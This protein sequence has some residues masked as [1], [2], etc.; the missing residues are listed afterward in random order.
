MK[1]IKIIIISVL[2]FVIVFVLVNFLLAGFLRYSCSCFTTL[3]EASCNCGT[4]LWSLVIPLVLAL[5]AAIYYFYRSLSSIKSNQKV[6][7]LIEK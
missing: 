5:G 4:P 7:K 1:K 2:L 3:P 6:E